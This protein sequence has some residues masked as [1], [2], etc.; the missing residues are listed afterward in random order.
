MTVHVVGTPV[1]DQLRVPVD[2]NEAYAYFGLD[3]AKKTLLVT[4]GSQGARGVNRAV[5]AI[6]D[7]MDPERL[8]CLHLTGELDYEET[9]R[10]YEASRVSHHVAPFCDRMDHAMAVADTAISRSGASSLAELATFG[11]P[12]VLIPYPYAA[13]DHQTLNAAPYV[14]GGAALMVEQETLTSE[15]LWGA[16]EKTWLDD[17]RREEMRGKMKDFSSDDANIK[18]CDIMET[19]LA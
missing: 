5:C 11:V 17:A 15:V 13:E 10:A 7:R 19:Q 9:R 6:L 12:A 3:P 8:Q 2:R 16:L 18:I 14:Q 4:G 1:R